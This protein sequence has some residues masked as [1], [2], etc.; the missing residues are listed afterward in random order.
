MKKFIVFLIFLNIF[1]IS[2]LVYYKS[3]L[4]F[5]NQQI[6]ILKL[7]KEKHDFSN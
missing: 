4:M 3:K 5:L 2:L 7:D 6:N 1:S